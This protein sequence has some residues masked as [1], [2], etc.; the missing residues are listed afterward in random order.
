MYEEAAKTE[1][2]RESGWETES[3]INLFSQKLYI[4]SSIATPDRK[5]RI[6]EPNQP[7]GGKY[8]VKNS[9]VVGNE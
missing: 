6:W 5:A 2:S 4:D 9:P 1:H 7:G 3:R 8:I